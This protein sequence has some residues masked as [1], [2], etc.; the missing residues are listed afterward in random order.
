MPKIGNLGGSEPYGKGACQFC[1]CAT[2]T[3]T[4]KTKSSSEVLEIQS[5]PLD[6]NPQNVFQPL[7]FIMSDDT[8]YFQITKTRSVSDLVTVK[9]NIGH[10]EVIKRF[11]SRYA[12]YCYRYIDN[13]EVT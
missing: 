9:V 5:G 11:H 13:W 6:C 2:R 1:E 8:R 10:L 3:R 12:K 7:K 4:R